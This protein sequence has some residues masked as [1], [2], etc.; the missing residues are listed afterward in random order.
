MRDDAV[1]SAISAIGHICDA[2]TFVVDLTARLGARRMLEPEAIDIIVEAGRIHCS[3]SKKSA[4]DIY[5]VEPFGQM[6]GHADGI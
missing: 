3:R 5:R 2:L 6:N 1:T 4:N